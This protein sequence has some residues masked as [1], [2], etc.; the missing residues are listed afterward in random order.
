[1]YNDDFNPPKVPGK[2]DVTGEP[3]SK[4]PDDTPEVFSKRLTHY[5]AETAPLLEYFAQAYPDAVHS[6]S[7]STSDEIW[8]KLTALVDAAGLPHRQRDLPTADPEVTHTR[9]EADDL[10]DQ[11]EVPVGDSVAHLR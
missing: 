3:L 8:P 4:R 2:D 10:R 5:Y 7:G 6:L 11:K 1:V 9:E